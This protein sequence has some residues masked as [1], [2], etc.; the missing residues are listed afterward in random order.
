MAK[1]DA[2][3]IAVGDA[4]LLAGEP[5][6]PDAHLRSRGASRRDEGARDD[7]ARLAPR[8]GAVGAGGPA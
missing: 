1:A 3:P 2:P 8:A 4:Q 6:V 7:G 5:P